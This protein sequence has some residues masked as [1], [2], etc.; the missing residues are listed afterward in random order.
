VE[1]VGG[2]YGK[3]LI[4]RL[5]GEGV[6]LEGRCEGAGEEAAAAEDEDCGELH[7]VDW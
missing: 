4:E 1:A 7:G 2:A 5:F 6:G 3:G